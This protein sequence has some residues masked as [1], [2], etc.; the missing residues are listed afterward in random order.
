MRNTYILHYVINGCGWFCDGKNKYTI[1]P[2]DIFAIYPDD[3]VSYE[4]DENEPWFFA[5][6]RFGGKRRRNITGNRRKPQHAGIGDVVIADVFGSNIVKQG[7][8]LRGVK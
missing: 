2:G 1:N 5:L 8:T 4:A 6:L 3:V 7:I